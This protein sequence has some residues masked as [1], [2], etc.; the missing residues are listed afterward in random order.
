MY[1]TCTFCHAPLGTNESLEAFPV[2]RRLAFDA[3][4]GRLWV[5]CAACKQ[6]NLSPL[7][8]RWEAIE[9][10]NKLY[11]DTRLRIA[12]EQI[13]LARLRDGTELIRIGAPL[14]PEFAAWRY[15]ERFTLRQRR[16]VVRSAAVFGGLTTLVGLG[17]LA[18]AGVIGLPWSA[19]TWGAMYVQK[20]RVIARFADADG[21]MT[22]TSWQAASARIVEDEEA[23]GGWQL[24][25]PHLRADLAVG[26]IGAATDGFERKAVFRGA[27]A[28]EVARRL[29]PQVNREGARRSV[30]DR[31]VEVLESTGDLE[32]TF[33]RAS[34]TIGRDN[35]GDASRGLA[36][37]PAEVR[38][39]LEMASHE[40]IERRALEGELAALEASWKEAE[41]VAAI[42]DS[43]TLPQWMLDRIERLGGR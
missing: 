30:V 12:T 22:F 42:A 10:A 5:V 13:G 33:R 31:A 16:Y 36:F 4:K 35:L 23:R 41:E 38:L 2:G 24:V 27:D 25:V 6:W 18:G 28:V 37:L 7:D 43:L 3:E 8:E 15:G 34:Q 29:L 9:A 39:A 20:R 11:R 14:R 26:R 32:A 40:D 1:S 21:P 17:W 19:Y